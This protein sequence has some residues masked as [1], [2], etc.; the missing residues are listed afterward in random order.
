MDLLRAGIITDPYYRY[1]DVLERWV[2]LDSWF[3]YRS[4][5]VPPDVASAN[6][7][8][9]VC[10]GIDT[11]AEISINGHHV[12][13][14]TNMFR[15]YVFDVK[16]FINP[17]NI[18]INAKDSHLSGENTISVNFTSAEVYAKKQALLYPYTVPGEALHDIL[19]Y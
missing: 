15:K 6:R 16:K 3:Y 1:N 17:G 9:L 19:T 14:T 10:E 5:G 13:H 7:V 18:I 11:V 8:L 12:G 2:G 4:F